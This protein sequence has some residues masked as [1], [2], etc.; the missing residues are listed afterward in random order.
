[1]SYDIT[2]F[3]SQGTTMVFSGQEDGEVR[4]QQLSKQCEEITTK[5]AFEQ[6]FATPLYQGEH[7]AMRSSLS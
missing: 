5:L 4:K 6:C 1:M 7:K 3:C 2:G